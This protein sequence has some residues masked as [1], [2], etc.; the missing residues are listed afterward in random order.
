MDNWLASSGAILH[1][2]IQ[3]GKH[4]HADQARSLATA[5]ERTAGIL[6]SGEFELSPGLTA[7]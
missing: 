1:S 5:C 2:S 7:G 3:T 4:P 6:P